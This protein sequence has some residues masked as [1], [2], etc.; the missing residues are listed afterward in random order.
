M[1]HGAFDLKVGQGLR[2]PKETYVT[3]EPFE[4]FCL[5]SQIEFKCTVDGGTITHKKSEIEEDRE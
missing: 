2:Y 1:V 5:S 3:K 4:E